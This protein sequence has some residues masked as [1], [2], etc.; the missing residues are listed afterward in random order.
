MD[1]PTP[2]GDSLFP[3]Q[4]KAAVAAAVVVVVGLGTLTMTALVSSL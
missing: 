4:N 1:S 2:R 3:V